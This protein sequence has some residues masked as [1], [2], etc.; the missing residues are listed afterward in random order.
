MKFH[1]GTPFDCSIVKFSYERAVAPDS[2]NAQ[3]G[4]LNRLRARNALIPQP[5][6]LTLARPTS[7]FLFNMGWGDAVMVAPNSAAGNKTKPVGTGPFR[8]QA[9]GAGRPRGA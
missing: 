8:V 1:D 5:L 2:T 3:R 9:L 7:N 6:S 4:C